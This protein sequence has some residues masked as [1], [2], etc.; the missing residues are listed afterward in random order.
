MDEVH[1]DVS[2]ADGEGM[3]YGE[4]CIALCACAC[5]IYIDPFLSIAQVSFG[6]IVQIL[7]QF[8]VH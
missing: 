2:E 1:E 7:A 4:Y 8:C 5:H 6:F 3:G